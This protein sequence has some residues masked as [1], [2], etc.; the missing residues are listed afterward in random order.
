M[1][2][3]RHH[4]LALGSRTWTADHVLLRHVELVVDWRDIFGT[5]FSDG[6]VDIGRTRRRDLEGYSSRIH[7]LFRADLERTRDGGGCSSGDVEV[8]D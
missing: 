1:V 6:R 2:R 3:G 7:H 4:G 5:W 8:V